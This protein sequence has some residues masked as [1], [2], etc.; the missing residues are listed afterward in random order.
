MV[1]SHQPILSLVGEAVSLDINVAAL[2]ALAIAR[3]VATHNIARYA[4]TKDSSM[5]WCAPASVV[6]IAASLG[7]WRST[8]ARTVGGVDEASSL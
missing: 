1:D 2:K 7:R 4:E 3:T 6:S 5:A 8:S